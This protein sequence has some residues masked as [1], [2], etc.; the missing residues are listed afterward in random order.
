MQ[1]KKTV[2]ILVIIII[3]I[4]GTSR[5]GHCT[6]DRENLLNA[7]FPFLLQTSV[8]LYGIRGHFVLLRAQVPRP[9]RAPNT[10]QQVFG[11]GGYAEGILQRLQGERTFSPSPGS[12]LFATARTDS[13][14]PLQTLNARTTK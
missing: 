3:V 4:I 11:I 9:E 13:G 8:K 12:S 10:S 1:C 14:W 6:R 2:G 7:T 5:W